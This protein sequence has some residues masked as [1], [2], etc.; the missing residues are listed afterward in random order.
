[1][2]EMPMNKEFKNYLDI[3]QLHKKIKFNTLFL[4]ITNSCNCK[5]KHCYNSSGEKKAIEFSMEE[6]NKT[7][8]EFLKY[9]IT[10]VVLSG[11]EALLH[12]NI[13]NFI[14]ILR[15]KKLDVT[16]LTNGKLLN[17]ES[18]KRLKSRKVYIQLSLDG[19]SP[20]TNDF[21]R[22]KGSFHDAMNALTVLNEQKYTERL[23][24]NTV[25]NSVNCNEVLDIINICEK[26]SVSAI[27]FNFL[28]NSGRAK[29]NGLFVTE[30]ELYHTIN[31]I[32]KNRNGENIKVRPINVT[33]KCRFCNCDDEVF[34]NPVVDVFGNVY[35][36]EFLRDEVFSIGNVF[37]KTLEDILCDDPI[38][39]NLLLLNIRQSYIKS[40]RNCAVKSKCGAGCIV[41]NND[42]NYFEPKFCILIKK[43]FLNELGGSKL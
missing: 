16:L 7:V 18:V 8:S 11:G 13:W 43:N 21:I 26:F 32:N 20:V 6:F 15:E 41:Q 24:V 5:C 10:S 36:C 30:N 9:K 14:D 42:D 4:E 22:E 28:N 2:I 31:R 40:C 38:K 17:N 29:K 35:M 23:S 12:P 19:A 33:H 27:G 25:I 1:M 34:L 39:R 3:I 37:K